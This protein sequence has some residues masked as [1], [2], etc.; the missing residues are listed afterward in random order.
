MTWYGWLLLS[1]VILEIIWLALTVNHMLG[2]IYMLTDK[3]VLIDEINIFDVQGLI[4]AV[5]ESRLDT[6][7]KVRLHKM[8]D[9]WRNALSLTKKIRVT[10]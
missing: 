3:D 10:F 9:R 1:I 5:D 6:E 2:R 4:T 8:L 7:E